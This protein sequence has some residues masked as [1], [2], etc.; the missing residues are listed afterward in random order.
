MCYQELGV[1]VPPEYMCPIT[2]EIM[3]D[4][5]ILTDGHV[6]EKRAIERWLLS[7]NTSPKTNQVVERGQLIRCHALRAII[8]EF[9]ENALKHKPNPDLASVS[10]AVE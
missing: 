8:S 2:M 3:T 7:H 1:A 9:V 6:Y 10:A 5:V 4:P